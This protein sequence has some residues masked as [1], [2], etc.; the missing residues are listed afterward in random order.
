MHPLRDSLSFWSSMLGTAI[1][2]V[3]LFRSSIVIAAA[4]LFLAALS[5]AA[6]LYA[7]SERN[8]LTR[9]TIAIQGRSIDALNVASLNRRLN[10][11]LIVQEAEQVVTVSGEDMTFTWRYS[12]YCR[13]YRE[14][15]I[16]FSVDAESQIPFERLECFAYDLRRDPK[17][18][19]RIRPILRGP[20]GLSK[21]IS[22][23]LLQPLSAR[24]AF[25]VLLTCTLP[26]CIKSGIEYYSS[27][28]SVAQDRIQT[29]TVRLIFLGERP[30][31]LRVYEC[32]LSGRVTLLKDLSP[33]RVTNEL[34]EY[35][36]SASDVPAQSAQIYVFSRPPA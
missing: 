18:M 35:A 10:R 28:L 15:A 25:S 12:G 22:A 16:E 36:D 26:G 14:T 17:R 21:K 4:G 9:A 3:G 1:A 29:S 20:D 6:L 7:G 11:S 27:T 30:L 5:A 23:P 13:A 33:S 24:E 32:G 19:H 34:V 31:W 2:I 8:R